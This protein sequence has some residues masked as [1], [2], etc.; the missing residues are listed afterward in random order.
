[1]GRIGVPVGPK[2]RCASCWLPKRCLCVEKGA[3]PSGD[4][5]RSTSSST[6]PNRSRER[7]ENCWCDRA[8]CRGD[9]IPHTGHTPLRA[10]GPLPRS[11]LARRAGHPTAHPRGGLHTDPPS[12]HRRRSWH[13][14][15][16]E[17]DAWPSY[18]EGERRRRNPTARQ[19]RR[20]SCCSPVGHA[21]RWH[22]PPWL[23]AAG[24]P[25]AKPHRLRKAGRR[26]CLIQND[27]SKY[28]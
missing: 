11:Q 19:P 14:R 5:P 12:R 24:G 21:G 2:A 20:T 16:T 13:H 22:P 17:L 28:V 8:D 18:F 26:R 1:M 15:V 3:G 7:S 23:D 6:P 10:S 25:S 4:T 27:R 9:R